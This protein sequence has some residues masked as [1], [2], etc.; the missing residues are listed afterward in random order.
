MRSNAAALLPKYDAEALVE[1]STPGLASAPQG[2]FAAGR[3][4][5]ALAEGDAAPGG[6]G[7]LQP[8]APAAAARA[9]D[10]DMA[11]SFGASPPLPSAPEA[12]MQP[13]AAPSADILWPNNDTTLSAQQMN[14]LSSHHLAM[15]EVTPCLTP[16]RSNP[17]LRQRSACLEVTA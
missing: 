13:G 4:I 10:F 17:Q 7:A 6:G 15:A 8:R 11:A 14:F 16:P 12:V 2:G 9:P 5:Y 1:A 3:G